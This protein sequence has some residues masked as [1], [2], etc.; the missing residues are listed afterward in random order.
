[1]NDTSSNE[2]NNNDTKEKPHEKNNSKFNTK[3]KIGK[4]VY[5][6][7]TLYL[8]ANKNLYK[9]KNKKQIGFF[10]KTEIREKSLLNLPKPRETDILI[11]N[12]RELIDLIL[13]FCILTNSSNYKIS[14]FNSSFG[15]LENNAKLLRYTGYV[16]YAKINEL[17]NNSYEV[18]NNIFKTNTTEKLDNFKRINNSTFKIKNLKEFPK[19]DSKYEFNY[20]NLRRTF[21]DN[22]TKF[23]NARANFTYFEQKKDESNFNENN[24]ININDNTFRSEIYNQINFQTNSYINSQYKKLDKNKLRLFK[25]KPL[26]S[27]NFLRESKSEIYSDSTNTY[28]F[29]PKK[30]RFFWNTMNRTNSQQ[31]LNINPEIKN[32]MLSNI[33]LF[34]KTNL[35]NKSRNEFMSRTR[36]FVPHVFTRFSRENKTNIENNNKDFDE[37]KTLFFINK[38]YTKENIL[39]NLERKN[40]NKLYKIK[41]IKNFLGNPIKIISSPN[42]LYSDNTKKFAVLKDIFFLFKNELNN[43]SKNLDNYISDKDIKTF[44]NEVD[45]NFKSLGI[46]LIYCLKEYFLYVY[47]NAFLKKNYP[48]VIEK[49]I[50]YNP[51]ITVEQMKEIINSLINHLKKLKVENKFDLVDFVRTLKNLNSC[52]LSSDFFLIF[53][54][55]P[56]YFNLSKQEIT[57]KFLL[58]LEIDCTKNIVTIDNFI[59]YYYIFRYGHLVELKQRI[60]FINKLLHLMEVKGSPLQDKIVSDIGYL[61]NIDNRTKQVLLGKIDDTK[62]SYHNNLKVNEIFDSII[63]FFK[64]KDN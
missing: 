45:D 46:N 2:K 11:E 25:T 13:S 12:I 30:L 8:I 20:K 3:V 62:L 33:D 48:E 26:F 9:D 47:F 53:V 29:P 1:M 19:L 23:L 41:L 36:K 24:N 14:V 55:C 44:Y 21:S 54:F 40:R 18:E 7:R 17:K 39:L 10:L 49:N 63:T 16:L 4:E 37:L 38:K 15:N 5:L 51:D 31:I 58:V 61:F 56:D 32:T 27:T 64:I 50:L 60:F 6:Y 22:N 42:Y 35:K 34:K 57:K 59:N 28:R 43:F 52:Q